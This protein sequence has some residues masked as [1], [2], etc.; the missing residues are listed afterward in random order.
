MVEAEL[1][2]GCVNFHSVTTDSYELSKLFNLFN[3]NGVF[4]LYMDSIAASI[5]R[6]IFI[7]AVKLI[8]ALFFLKEVVSCHYNRRFFRCL[9][10]KF[11]FLFF[12]Y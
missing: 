6:T 3:E 11:P 4:S 1:P 8:I 5:D 9:I 2:L 10:G 7:E 12:D